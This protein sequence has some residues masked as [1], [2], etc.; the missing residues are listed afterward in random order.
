MKTLKQI[1]KV[2]EI[3]VSKESINTYAALY[4]QQILKDFFG[5]TFNTLKWCDT[6]RFLTKSYAHGAGCGLETNSEAN[7]AH[8]SYKYY[9][10]SDEAELVLEIR[11]WRVDATK[12]ER[13]Y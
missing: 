13:K 6:L 1:T 12:V 3:V 8:F 5:K 11:M 10:C 2:E 9:N 4:I 7:A